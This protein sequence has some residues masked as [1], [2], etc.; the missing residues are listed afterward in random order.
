[1]RPD[2]WAARGHL[3]LPGCH[4]SHLL[5]KWGQS[6]LHLTASFPQDTLVR[7]TDSASVILVLLPRVSRG[8]VKIIPVPHSLPPEGHELWNMPAVRSR[9]QAW[10]Y[11]SCPGSQFPHLQNGDSSRTR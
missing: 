10:P 4:L 11:T 5:V 7:S 8:R 1:M 2:S 9:G 3:A 6:C